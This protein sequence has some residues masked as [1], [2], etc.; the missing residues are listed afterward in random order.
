M[1]NVKN[2][3][4]VNLFTN[5]SV[6]LGQHGL[7]APSRCGLSGGRRRRRT[8]RRNQRGGAGYGADFSSPAKG[9]TNSKSYSDCGV[10]GPTSVG[11]QYVPLL[12]QK[13][14]GRLTYGGGGS[15]SYGY[16]KQNSDLANTLKG[17]YA[18]IKR[19]V[20]P[21]CGGRK[22][23]R[24]KRRSRRR[25]SRRRTRRKRRCSKCPSRCC[26]CCKCRGG[27]RKSCRCRKCPQKCCPCCRCKKKHRKRRTKRT[28][29]SRGRRGGRKSQRRNQRGGYHQY[30]S[31]FPNTP[32]MKIP[33]G[34]GYKI[35]NPPTFSVLNSCVDNYNHYK[36][37]GSASPVLDKTV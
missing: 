4:S 17:G 35:A 26:A 11:K 10:T 32:G 34:G 37:S 28:R 2:Q 23:R 36:G 15:I 12:A 13:G 33:N 6:N 14:G 5:K 25:K 19:T 8:R 1:A 9:L 31:N 16:D 18:P 7:E 22:R 29:R 24:R 21:Q 27:R 30:R 20:Q 3:H